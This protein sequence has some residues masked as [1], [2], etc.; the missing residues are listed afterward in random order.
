M[1]FSPIKPDNFAGDPLGYGGNFCGHFMIPALIAGII[2]D[3]WL[4]L[5]AGAL[6]WIAE[7][8]GLWR[9]PP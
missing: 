5:A 4:M 2:C 3:L 9:V 7:L 8:V 1:R 6:A